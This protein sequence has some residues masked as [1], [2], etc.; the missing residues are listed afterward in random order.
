VYIGFR[1]YDE[2]DLQLAIACWRCE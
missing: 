1:V 2:V